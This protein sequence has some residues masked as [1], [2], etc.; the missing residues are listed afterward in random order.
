MIEHEELQMRSSDVI[1]RNL[2]IEARREMEIE[3]R[4]RER[5]LIGSKHSRALILL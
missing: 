3:K 1:P 4:D 5:D 2:K